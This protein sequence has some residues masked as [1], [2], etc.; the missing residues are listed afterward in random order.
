MWT[1]AGA[2]FSTT[3][4]IKLYLCLR[5]LGCSWPEIE[6]EDV[7]W[8]LQVT[9]GGPLQ[10][11]WIKKSSEW[12]SFP[13]LKDICS[14]T[15]GPRFPPCFSAQ[16]WS[17]L[18]LE[19]MSHGTFW[20]G[21]HPTGPWGSVGSSLCGAQGWGTGGAQGSFPVCE[22][23]FVLRCLPCCPPFLDGLLSLDG[24]PRL[25]KPALF[26]CQNT[27][28]WRVLKSQAAAFVKC[29]GHRGPDPS[30]SPQQLLRKFNLGTRLG[31]LS[32][33]CPHTAWPSSPCLAPTCGRT[34]H[35]LTKP[36]SRHPSHPELH[37]LHGSHPALEPLSHP[38]GCE[39][40]RTA[41][42]FHKALHSWAV[43]QQK[44]MVTGYSLGP[45]GFS[46]ASGYPTE[47]LPAPREV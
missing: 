28:S 45:V 7:S 30:V 6:T 18:S 14:T 13:S 47:N 22:R 29:W 27:P 9:A 19:K 31:F 43:L 8:V 44:L 4:A 39:I 3:S 46:N 23:D 24:L 11:T 12:V 10:N 2:I 32:H 17:A 21:V 16:R 25:N 40:D 1:T 15:L 34:F 35:T 36:H 38:Q 37:Q 42:W 5:L 20:W 26:L 33:Q 41:Q